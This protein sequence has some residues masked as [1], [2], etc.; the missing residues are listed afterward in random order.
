MNK[1]GGSSVRE[2]APN[3]EKSTLVPGINRRAHTG[4]HGVA[5]VLAQTQKSEEDADW[6]G[7]EARGRRLTLS[8]VSPNQ[9]HRSLLV[10]SPRR[11]PIVASR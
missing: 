8:A 11:T 5:G 3:K 4:W 10:F 9:A 6:P 1:Q 7:H 2:Y